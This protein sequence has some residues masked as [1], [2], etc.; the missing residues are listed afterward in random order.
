MFGRRETVN[1]LVVI[2]IVGVIV[3]NYTFSN[4]TGFRISFLDVGQGDSILIQTD[5]GTNILIDGGRGRGVLRQ[6]GKVLGHDKEIDIVIAT[7]VDSDHIGG[8][9]G[10]L[11]TYH[12]SQVLTP[13]FVKSSNILKLFLD[14]VSNEGIDINIVSEPFVV[15]F[16][17]IKMYFLWPD[18]EISESNANS[19]IILLEYKGKKILLTGDAPSSIEEYIFSQNSDILMNIDILKAGHHGS[20]T[21]SSAKFLNSVLPEYV[22]L[23]YGKNNNYGHPCQGVLE[24]IKS[25][26]A[27]ILETKDGN[28]TFEY[29]NGGLGIK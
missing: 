17:G 18:R 13:N 11:E 4:S 26:G 20:C 24:N 10:V 21:S 23:S 1:L 12:V 15:N 6:L 14:S 25:V 2:L 29:L 22:I 8:L 3:Y 9:V 19:V 5:G 28:I 27:E 16:D 7:H